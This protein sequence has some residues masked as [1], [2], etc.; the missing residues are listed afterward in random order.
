MLLDKQH[1]NLKSGI[2]PLKKR[3]HNNTF[4]LGSVSSYGRNVPQEAF[5]PK[6][7][8]YALGAIE[9]ADSFLKAKLG[10]FHTNDNPSFIFE[11]ENYS[12]QNLIIKSIRINVPQR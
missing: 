10:C 8:K 6:W 7:L 1:Q 11:I 2:L 9:T 12:N 5:L 4:Y 3:P